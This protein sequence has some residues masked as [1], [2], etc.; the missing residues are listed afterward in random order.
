MCTYEYTY[1]CMYLPS[2]FVE[3]TYIM[4]EFIKY[5]VFK[6]T[7]TCIYVSTSIYTHARV[8]VCIRIFVC[9]IYLFFV[10]NTYSMF[11][12]YQH[13]R[14]EPIYIYIYIYPNVKL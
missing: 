10:K 13:T 6:N 2:V 1:I 11:V 9:V 7:Y 8:F 12:S 5:L 3:N 4:F 14:F